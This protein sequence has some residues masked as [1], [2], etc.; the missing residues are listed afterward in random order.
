MEIEPISMNPRPG[1]GYQLK[2][3]QY[4]AM[5]NIEKNYL[6]KEW[7]RPLALKRLILYI[8]LFSAIYV[9]ARPHVDPPLKADIQ[10]TITGTITDNE[11]TPLPRASI[12]EKGTTNGT[13]TDFDGYY[14]LNISN[15]NATLVISYIGFATQEIAVNGQTIISINLEESASGLDEVVV[16]GY[17]T[18]KKINLTGAVDIVNS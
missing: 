6:F 12:V 2:I 10:I 5:K 11:V 14:S 15:E 16:V 7:G 3:S 8:F 1:K 13:Q 17:G 9:S 4:K 18:Q